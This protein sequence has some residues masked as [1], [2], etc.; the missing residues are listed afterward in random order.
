MKRCPAIGTRNWKRTTVRGHFEIVRQEVNR[1]NNMRRYLTICLSSVLILI[2]PCRS[3]WPDEILLDDYQD[4]LSPKWEE[5]SFEGKTEYQVTLEDNQLC[6]RASSNASASGLYYKIDYDTKQ[7]PLL[8]WSWKVDHIVSKG[9]ARYKDGD[10]YAAR[11]YVIFPSWAFWK[12]KALNYVWA[13]KLPKGEAVPN[14]FTK[15][16]ITIA[17]ESGPGRTGHWTEGKRNVFEDYRR[18][19][20]GEPPKVGAIAIMTDTDNTGEAATAWYGP[21]TILSG[22]SQ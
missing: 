22:S 21:I 16:A 20:G 15:N 11:V 18:Y 5:K 2:S 19:F 3:A 8:M 7:Y 12:T 4:G 13:N 14:P 17:V 9:D 10:D 6:I 1:K